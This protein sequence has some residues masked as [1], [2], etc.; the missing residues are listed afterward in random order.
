MK[1]AKKL[2]S[3][4]L[5]AMMVVVM[6]LGLASC[7]ADSF[8]PGCI[9]IGV[10]GPLTGGAAVY[11]IAVE[12][13]ARMAVDEINAAGGVS[14]NGKKVKIHLVVMDDQHKAENVSTNYASLLEKGM[15]VSLACVTSAPAMEF[16]SAAVKDNLFFLTPSA[17]ADAVVKD[18]PYGYQM[19]FADNNQGSVAAAYVNEH[20]ADKKIGVLYRS[21]DVYSTGI[22]AKFEQTI[23]TDSLVKASF[24]GDI[25]A[26][27]NSQINTLK[28]CDLIFMPIYYTPA[29]Q[30]MTEAKATMKADAV[31]YGC[32]GLDGIDTAVPGF[33]ISKIPQEVSFLSH[34]NSKATSGAAKDFIDKYTEKYGADSLNQFGASA[35]DCVYAIKAAFEKAGTVN[36]DATPADVSSALK[37]VF[38]D[39]SFRFT[40]V[41][42][43]NITWDAQGYVQKTAQ[44]FVVKSADAK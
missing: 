14:V 9:N 12:N 39:P 20:Y 29:S 4:V 1:N 27:F 3:L 2:V 44:K 40:G 32:D 37:A 26:S 31:Y 38:S 22:L 16:K 19:C 5:A 43:T 13:S 21:D 34:F 15:N 17:S 36:L 30:F 28:D 41:T 7:G 11:G 6:V 42:G 10:S 8:Q 18:A 24:S 25:V 35:Y 23:H 33:D